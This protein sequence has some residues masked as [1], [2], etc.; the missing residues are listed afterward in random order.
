RFEMEGLTLW[1][2]ETEPV[3]QLH[4]RRPAVLAPVVD[5]LPVQAAADREVRGVRA[6]VEEGLRIGDEAGVRSDC[7][8]GV[9]RVRDVSAGGVA[10]E[11]EERASALFTHGEHGQPRRHLGYR[12]QTS[13]LDP[14]RG[15]GRNYRY[16]DQRHEHPPLSRS[17]LRLRYQRIQRKRETR[18]VRGHETI[19]A[20]TRP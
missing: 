3:D 11:M 18:F 2:G 7:R 6:P 9:R 17:S 16:C 19:I 4:L 12:P 1:T 13:Q 15:S 8:T 5:R 14:E 10:S 20:S